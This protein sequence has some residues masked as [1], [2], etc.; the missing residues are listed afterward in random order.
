MTTRTM[1][2]REKCRHPASQVLWQGATFSEIGSDDIEMSLVCC[3]CGQVFDDMDDLDAS[4]GVTRL[5]DMGN[6]PVIVK[7]KP[8]V[9]GWF[10]HTGN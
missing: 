8:K 3:Y 2:I 9:T 7:E 6:V 4:R 10:K 1:K 5:K